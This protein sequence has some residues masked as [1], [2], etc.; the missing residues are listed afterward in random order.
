MSNQHIDSITADSYA[1]VGLSCRLPGAKDKHEFWRLLT[2]ASEHMR[3]TP[4]WRWSAKNYESSDASNVPGLMSS[5]RGG[6]IPED[7]IKG[8]F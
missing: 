6:Y 3:D 8:M 7:Q 4:E 2:E 5:S 1:I